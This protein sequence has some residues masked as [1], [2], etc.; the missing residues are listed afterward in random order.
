M[1]PSLAKPAGTKTSAIRMRPAGPRARRSWSSERSLLRGATVRADAAQIASLPVRNNPASHGLSVSKSVTM[2]SATGWPVRPV[3]ISASIRR[4]TFERL[5]A[6]D[7]RRACRR[8]SR[9][10]KSAMTAR[11]PSCG[12]AI[13]SAPVPPALGVGRQVEPA[14]VVPGDGEAGAGEAR[15]AALAGE[16]DA[17]GEA[18]V[19][20]GRGVDHPERAV[21]EADRGADD[22]LGLHAV[23]RRG[24]GEA[25]HLGD[26]AGER[27]ASGRG[28][29]C[30][31]SSARRRRRGRA[32]RGRARRSRPADARGGSSV[33]QPTIRPSAPSARRPARRSAAGRKRCC[34]TTPRVTPAARQAA[35]SASARAVET[36]SGFSSRTCLPAAAARRDE[37]ADGCSAGVQDQHRVDGRA[38]SRIASRLVGQREREA[39]GEGGAARLGSG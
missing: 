3:S 27:A 24:G 38:S 39:R 20:G 8:G 15:G 26:R 34:S 2:C 35:T 29:G 4:W 11:W 9:R 6:G 25:G 32:C 14:A 31:G 33:E 13:G 22:V 5:G 19:G 1:S 16:L 18:R 36:S 17:L 37:V 21:R 30:P 23:H 7:P 28:C 12:K 10:R